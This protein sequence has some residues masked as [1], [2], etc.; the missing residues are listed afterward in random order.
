M[1]SLMELLR[2]PTR[3]PFTLEDAI[4]WSGM[5]EE[6]KAALLERVSSSRQRQARV[7]PR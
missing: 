6:M 1:N 7:G 3:L 5:D 2:A 4:R